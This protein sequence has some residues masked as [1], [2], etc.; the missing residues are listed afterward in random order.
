MSETVESLDTRKRF[1]YPAGLIA[2]VAM[3][4]F[5]ITRTM[6]GQGDFPYHIGFAVALAQGELAVPHILLHALTAEGILLGLTPTAAITVVILGFQVLAAWGVSWLAQRSGASAG[7]AMS[8]G[9]SI[10][11]V[12]PILPLEIAADADVYPAG[13]FLPNA[14]NNPTVT[15]AKAFVPFLIELGV[16]LS[17]AAAVTWSWSRI[18]AIVVFAGLAKPHYV[19]CLFPVVVAA[20]AWRWWGGHRVSW[21][22]V[23]S[24]TI[25]GVAVL[26][27][28]A[29]GTTA[30]VGGGTAIIAP[31]AVL[32]SW[33]GQDVAVDAVS[34]AARACSDG[35]FPITVLVLWPDARRFPALVLAWA[36]YGV[37]L[38]QGLLL[39]ET[40]YRMLDGNFMWSPQLATFGV[41]AASAAW[42]GRSSARWN[43]R[44]MIAWSVLAI[45]VAYGVWWI[46]ARVAAR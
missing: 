19:S 25:A 29:I 10:V 45:H 31:L 22:P 46:S 17:G 2:I 21:G 23:L 8:L 3:G 13:Y 36:A 30:L 40:G 24:F 7:V 28:T 6:L 42:L 44:V 38:A 35:A 37:G 4:Y 20:C 41:M 33:G 11:F 39:A 32:R 14:L 16:M 9:V 34:I 26:L 43:W 15:A 12:A 18:A 1:L 5:P 27:W